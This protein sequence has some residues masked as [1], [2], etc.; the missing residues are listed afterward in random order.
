MTV[1]PSILTWARVTAGLPL[2][3]AATAL[4][5]KDSRKRSGS[6]RL[7]ALESGEEEVSRGVLL[8]MVKKYRRPLLVFY[9]SEPPPKGDRGQ[10]FRTA[11]N[12]PP[13]QFDPTL[14]A[15][16]RN[17]KGRQSIVRSL[18]EDIDAEI[19][20]FIGSAT[21]AVPAVEVANRIVTR[22]GFSLQEFR[23][24]SDVSRAFTYLRTK[25]EAAGIFV[26]LLGNLG[27]HHS[28]ISAETFRGFAI[29][30]PLA[31][32]VVVNDQDARPAWSFTTLH[33]VA[34]LWLGTTGVSGSG[35]EAQIER[36]CNDVAGEILFPASEVAR[37]AHIRQANLEAAIEAISQFANSAKIS[38]AMV[39]YKLFRAGI[40]NQS[41]WSGLR[42]HFSRE[43]LESKTRQEGHEGADSGPSYYV[44]KRHRLGAALLELVGHSLAEGILTPAK[45]GQVL[46]VKPRNVDPLLHAQAAPF[47]REF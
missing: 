38:R 37:L 1:N 3:Q 11:P 16:I 28:K 32:F 41:M 31:P 19:V 24:Q 20:D 36:Y 5:F 13:P 43:Y 45:A 40:F 39:A 12:M 9:L 27:S 17:V 34:H 21:T 35:M 30:D 42:D 8:N 14:D 33:E 18:L 25:V 46:G 23:R 22:L 15:L 44:V 2:D 4:G 47:G 7:A 29:S 10:D 26:L 6:E